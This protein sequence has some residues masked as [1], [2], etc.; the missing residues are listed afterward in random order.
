MKIWCCEDRSAVFVDVFRRSAI[1]SGYDLNL[2]KPGPVS[3]PGFDKFCS[4]Y[5][6]LSP[7]PEWF[8]VATFR[9]FFEI[10]AL[11]RPDD[12]FVL[13]DSDLVIQ[14]PFAGL[15]EEIR[16]FPGV[17]ASIGATAGVL[18]RDINSGFSIWTGRQ[19]RDFCDYAIARYEAGVDDF[20]AYRA[21]QIAGGNA[22]ASISEMTVSYHWIEESGTP[23]LN[24]N[25]VIDG[26]YV[27]HNFLMSECLG[28]R[29]AMTL[30][31]KAV[32]FTKTGIMLATDAGVPVRPASL[33]LGGRYK[34]MARDLEAGSQIGLAARSL[35]ILAGRAGR[36][37]LGAMRG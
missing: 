11:V 14:T 36:R 28:T 31:R 37:V 4:V 30:G 26:C 20:A 29:F 10:A 18:E 6:H 7:N 2:I 3:P 25:R 33:H 8:E 35:F 9:R 15:P 16:D 21:A 23:F 1:A 22:R 5:R 12:R 32:R 19:L 34:I 24:T 17:V 27:D 13:T